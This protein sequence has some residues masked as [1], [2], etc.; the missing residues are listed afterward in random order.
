[1]RRRDGCPPSSLGAILPCPFTTWPDDPLALWPHLSGPIDGL[2]FIFL[3]QQ[4]PVRAAK[5]ERIRERVANAHRT[6]RVRRVVEV[7][8]G[9]RLIEVDRGRGDLFTHRERRDAGFEPAGCA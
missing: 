4:R 6:L 1:M 7:A 5:A 2:S 8:R 9:I 3:E